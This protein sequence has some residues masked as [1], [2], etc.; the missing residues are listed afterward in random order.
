[1]TSHPFLELSV[2]KPQPIEKAWL[3]GL[4]ALKPSDR[5]LSHGLEIHKQSIVVD[6]YGLGV[7]AGVPET[8]LQKMK[9]PESSIREIQ[10][11][12]DEARVLGLANN[13]EEWRERMLAWR[14]SGLTCIV[15]NAGEESNNALLLLRRLAYYTHL[16]GHKQSDVFKAFSTDDIIQAKKTGKRCLYLMG[17][18]VPMPMLQQSV[19]DELDLI[20][21][22][23]YLG[24]RMMHLTYNRRN[25]IGDG[26]AESANG[27]LS[28]FG[29]AVVHEMNRVGV[30]VDLAHCGEQTSI[31]AARASAKPTIISHACAYA[32]NPYYRNKTDE[33]IR[34]VVEG[35]G[36]MGVTC[37]VGCLGRSHDIVALLDH[38]D[39]VAKRFGVDH[40]AFGTDRDY[41]CENDA[42]RKT[43]FIAQRRSRWEKFHPASPPTALTDTALASMTTSLTNFPL[44]SVGL[45]QRGYKDDDIRK[46]LGGNFLR[47]AKA[48][49]NPSAGTTEQRS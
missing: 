13:S 14:A 21:I 5:D 29:T 19:E 10:N 18:G 44:F 41:L 11:L 22:Y 26:C 9:R 48:N 6:T 25:F 3:A 28:D 42:V 45:V 39:Y 49:F 47:V 7:I 4:Q 24:W 33:V 23:F 16:T 8:I 30:I 37:L 46:I 15:Q 17:C 12:K 38:V 34:A 32:L 20:R 43:R 1:M 36:L 31:D 40:V 27:G 35:D 2:P